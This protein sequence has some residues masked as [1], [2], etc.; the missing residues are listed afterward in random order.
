MNITTMLGGRVGFWDLGRARNPEIRRARG[1]RRSNFF[2]RL[3]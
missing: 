2:I 3:V 1:R